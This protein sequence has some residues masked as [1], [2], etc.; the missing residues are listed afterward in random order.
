[1]DITSSPV[2]LMVQ[3]KLG[4]P[5]N[6]QATYE[7]EGCFRLTD[8]GTETCDPVAATRVTLRWKA[9]F[10][11]DVFGSDSE[12]LPYDV[13]IQGSDNSVNLAETTSSGASI[14]GTGDDTFVLPS[15]EQCVDLEYNVTAN[16]PLGA[17]G[18]ATIAGLAWPNSTELCVLYNNEHN[19][20]LLLAWEPL[21]NT[22]QQ[23]SIRL[24]RQDGQM[25]QWLLPFPEAEED[26]NI[27]R[28]SSHIE[29]VADNF[30][31]QGQQYTIILSYT[32]DQQS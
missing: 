3:G 19:E 23:A 15:V 6:L 27:T 18:T 28:N 4:R 7:T 16:N 8:T 11:L 1:M 24:T 14:N 29:L 20:R 22:R 31:Q 13:T 26:G 21:L 2:T 32:L 30:F 17:G 10:S 9:P 12:I 25:A 5:T